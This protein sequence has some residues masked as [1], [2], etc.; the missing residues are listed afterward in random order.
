MNLRR[1]HKEG[2]EVFTDSLGDIMFFL[3]LFFII[4]STLV[5]PNVINLDSPSSKTAAVLQQG[6]VTLA[7]DAQHNYYVNNLPVPFDQLQPILLA[8]LKAKNTQSIILFM[9]KSLSVQDVAD[10]MQLGSNLKV[11]LVLSVNPSK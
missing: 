6:K 3:L 10:V 1:K 8:E 11:K 2:A 9:D 7:V 4:I 5:N